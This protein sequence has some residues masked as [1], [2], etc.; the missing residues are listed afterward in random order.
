MVY[1]LNYKT[2]SKILGYFLRK[3]SVDHWRKVEN[4]FSEVNYDVNFES[5]YAFNDQSPRK[6]FFN[7]RHDCSTGSCNNY[8]LNYNTNSELYS[9]FFRSLNT[10]YLVTINQETGLVDIHW[11]WDYQKRDDLV[12]KNTSLKISTDCIGDKGNCFV[13]KL[14]YKTDSEFFGTNFRF[15]D[16][17]YKVEQVGVFNEFKINVDLLRP[18]KGQ[19]RKNAKLF[20]RADC[21][22]GLCR[23]YK[24]KY[25][26]NSEVLGRNFRYL[27]VDYKLNIENNNLHQINLVVDID[28][29]NGLT[30]T[31]LESETDCFLGD[32][33]VYKLNYKSDHHL[34]SYNFNE[35]VI[36]FWTKRSEAFNEIY[37]EHKFSNRWN[38]DQR[39]L[40]ALLKHNCFVGKCNSANLDYKTNQFYGK[41]LVKLSL[42]KDESNV[43]QANLDYSISDSLNR[44]VKVTVELNEDGTVKSFDY[45]TNAGEI[46]GTNFKLLKVNLNTADLE[47]DLN[48]L[49]LNVDFNDGELRNAKLTLR[50]DCPKGNCH[51]YYLLYQTDSDI[52]GRNFKLLNIDYNFKAVDSLNNQIDL[53][54]NYRLKNDLYPYNYSASILSD[55]FSLNGAC[56][57]YKQKFSTD[58][59]V[60]SPYRLLNIDWDT[61][62]ENSIDLLK[63]N[64]EYQRQNQQNKRKADF[65]LRTNCVSSKCDLYKLRYE[66]DCEFLGQNF[67]LLDFEYNERVVNGLF[68]WEYDIVYNLGSESQQKNFHLEVTHNCIYGP[69]N[70]YKLQYQANSERLFGYLRYLNFDYY[71]T[72]ENKVNKFHY[73]VDYQTWKHEKIVN[74]TLHVEHDCLTGRCKLYKQ[75]WKSDS[76][77]LSKNFRLFN[78]DYL[79]TVENKFDEHKLN[80]EY[81]AGFV[82]KVRHANLNIYTDCVV[83]SCDVYKLNY[84]TDS[85][86]LGR[87]FRLLKI[88]LKSVKNGKVNEYICELD[89]ISGFD[90]S[91]LR[92][93]KMTM[94]T[95]CILGDCNLYNH[96]FTTNS[97][98]LNIFF[99][100]FNFEYVANLD[101]AKF[102]NVFIKCDYQLPKEEITRNG[103]LSIRH[104]CIIGD[105]SVYKLNYKSNDNLVMA[106]VF[107]L[108]NVDY[109]SRVEDGINR[110]DLNAE[111][112][113]SVMPEKRNYELKFETDCVYGKC[114]LY[115]LRSET[116]SDYLGVFKFFD[117]VYKFTLNEDD[118]VGTMDLSFDYKTRKDDRLRSTKFY[119]VSDCYNGKCKDFSLDY[120][121]NSEKLSYNFQILNIQFHQQLKE[122][123]LNEYTYNLKYKL[124]DEIKLNTANLNV[125]SD[126][127]TGPCDKYELKYDAD[128][129]VFAK[130]FKLLRVNYVNENKPN[131]VNDVLVEVDHILY[132]EQEKKSSTFKLVTDC[133]IGQCRDY[134]LEYR[135]N[136]DYL[137]RNFKL[138]KIGYHQKFENGINKWSSYVDYLLSSE[139]GPERNSKIA[140]EYDC[141]IGKCRYYKLN[142]QS[143]SEVLG[144]KLKIF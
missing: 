53:T 104:D 54:I 39:Y 9:Y 51:V 128:S 24:L 61:S 18:G 114:R 32:C 48:E 132:F 118:K 40:S 77:F 44:N 117:F 56:K 116:N 7:T 109:S 110:I 11:D 113:L 134:D 6:I 135:S 90:P 83:G 37:Y 112:K 72:V 57:V 108:V 84:E 20:Y 62:V 1:K 58:S 138:L 88:D 127:L 68:N 29:G 12:P 102:V 73:S 34:L 2:D 80:I 94:F 95:D 43:V 63:I 66:T 92:S 105:C 91:N 133:A 15:I 38:V 139:T 49:T 100:N 79:N 126:C 36:D 13:Y 23:N 74:T 121:S 65:Y 122:N 99:T 78:I 22:A 123:K 69:C 19:T 89:Y 46:F 3:I 52:L 47:D 101:D 16:V 67:K 14:N 107:N 31:R 144:K 42:D 96:T 60:L 64:I 141:I 45:N 87:N 111:Y 41:H 85:E 71:D 81:D 55:C 59:P 137:G 115:N 130:N 8:R 76:E 136:S 10:D 5:G 21:S 119:V 4:D 50:T 143:N 131:K 142:Y 86:I 35:F 70:V 27:D 33:L 106:R 75:T 129:P 140:V 97:E 98:Y 124:R 103:L 93:S 17:D 82:K 30:K 25:E 120:T 125:V 26:T 28:S